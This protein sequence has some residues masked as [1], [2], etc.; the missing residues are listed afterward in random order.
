M[1]ATP[2]QIEQSRQLME[3]QDA[4]RQKAV[5]A[6]VALAVTST[7]NFNGWY[8]TTAIT[9][10]ALRLA[11]GIEGIQRNLARQTDVFLAREASLLSGRTVRP[12]G[13]VE[14]ATLRRNITH[15]GA[16]GRVAD[17]FRYQQS[18]VIAGGPDLQP[19]I[20]AAVERAEEVAAMDTQLAVRAQA[21]KFMEAQPEQRLI[22]YRRMVHPELAKSGAS[23]G[24]CIVASTRLYNKAELMPIHNNCHCLPFPV[25]EGA[26]P[27]GI[28]NDQDL[29]RFY[30]EAGGKQATELKNTRY[31]I[32]EHGELGPVLNKYGT[33]FRTPDDV[34]R[35][36]R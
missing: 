18:R 21:Q 36:E 16:Y 26:D 9:A 24:M 30:A 28:I 1:V 13:A 8:S 4:A 17:T 3:Q 7:R 15:P 29:E 22:G 12:V 2:Q 19:A 25:Y 14:V 27:G 6:A 32:D 23:C 34:Q 11:L 5:A 31:Q 35:D 10:W 20:E 33:P